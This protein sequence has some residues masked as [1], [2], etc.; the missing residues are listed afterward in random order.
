MKLICVFGP[1]ACHKSETAMYLAEKLNGE[2]LSCD[3]VAVYKGFDIGSAKPTAEEQRRAPHHLIDIA[4]PEDGTFSVAAFQKAADAV[5][6]DCVRRSKQPILAGG[7]GLYADAVLR[8]MGYA[9]PGNTEIRAKLSSEYDRSPEGFRDKVKAVDPEAGERI[10][11]KDKKRLVRAMEV[12][13][14]TGRPFSSF[15]EAYVQARKKLRYEAIMVGLTMER[16]A[17]YERINARVDAMM[18]QGL[19]EEARR[20]FDGIDDKSLPAMQS[21]GYAQLF[22]YFRGEAS[23]QDAV[24]QIKLDTRHLAKR[25][26]TWFKREDSIRWFDCGNWPDTLQSIEAYCQDSLSRLKGRV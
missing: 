4:E 17:L 5:I 6:D 13:T 21:I 16:N 3:S 12:Y 9:V 22:A 25:Q 2:I 19:L 14:I 7:S 26:L 18:A 11:L 24:E 23:L 1:T 20:I 10:P 15:N 8:E